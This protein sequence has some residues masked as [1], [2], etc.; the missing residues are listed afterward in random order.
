MFKNSTAAIFVL[1]AFTAPALADFDLS[2]HTIDSGGGFSAGGGFAL[3]GTIGQPDAGAM[4][5]GNF[6]LTGGFWAAVDSAA[7][8]CP[9]NHGDANCDGAINFFDID[10]F[11]DALFEPAAY[12][13]TYCGGSL[14]AADT[15][16]S[17]AVNF[18]DIDP[19]LT[20]LFGGCAACP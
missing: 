19:F 11:L 20:C 8:P 13:A 5:G 15:D 16:C 1:I 4:S 18:F 7:P 2:W 12:A 14:C 3:E 17:D 6:T 10:P 9:G